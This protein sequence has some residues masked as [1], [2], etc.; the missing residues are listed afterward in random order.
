MVVCTTAL[1]FWQ[2]VKKQKRGIGLKLVCSD[3]MSKIVVFLS[4]EP[5]V[6]EAQ[7]FACTTLPHILMHMPNL[8]KIGDGRK[9]FFAN[10]I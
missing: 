5:M 9:F 1:E 4:P 2:N 6:F 8:K 10:S 7:N 3:D